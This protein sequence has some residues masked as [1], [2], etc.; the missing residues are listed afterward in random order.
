M[1]IDNSL[2]YKLRIISAYRD[3]LRN[4]CALVTR[5]YIKQFRQS[6]LKAAL[7]LQNRNCLEVAFF[8]T[9]PG[10]WKL[11]S[12]YELMLKDSRYHPYVVIYPYSAY[13]GYEKNELLKT[14]ERTKRFIEQKGYEYVVPYDEKKKTWQDMKKLPHHPDIV[15]FTTPYKD[16]LPQYYIYHFQDTLTCYLPYAFTSLKFYK[17][18]YDLIFH[19][20][21]GLFFQETEIHKNL[22][23]KYGRNNG[24]NAVVTGYPSTEIYLNNNYS[25]SNPWKP[26]TREKKKL[27]Y[28]PHH[29]IDTD[30]NSTF[31]D[32]CDNIL[33]LAEKY[34]D[35]LHIAF[36]PHQTLKL[37]LQ[38]VWGIEKT[39]AYYQK[40]GTMENTQLVND[41]YEDLFLT[42]DAM[43]HD[44]GSFTTEY[45]FTK[46][47]VM[48]L[49]R[50]TDMAEKFN[51]FGVKSFN[52]HYQGHS[53]EDVEHFIQEVVINGNDPMKA[54]REQFFDEY[55]RPK[56]G[57]LPSQKILQVIENFIKGEKV[58]STN[59]YH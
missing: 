56:D 20:L 9:I 2:F 17:A 51:E 25:P 27:I 18:N 13:K 29:S 1:A 49:C 37:K 54:Q 53:I 4:H 57:I 33:S 3:V 24:E 35:D 50:T 6:Q 14:L 39:E 34:K 59:I 42:S 19:N 15:F 48:Y 21:V 10:M 5:H 23:K 12:L 46:K 47:P 52:C 16:V 28:A 55:L 45:L 38:K 43:I 31:F 26:Q 8:L 30:H 32:Y 11:D 58:S 22:A 40:W 7:Q 44:C 36:K 41:G